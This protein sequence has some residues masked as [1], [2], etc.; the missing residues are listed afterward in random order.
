MADIDRLLQMLRSNNGTTR[1]D[2]CEELRMASS[3]PPEAIAALEATARDP[4]LIVADAAQRALAAHRPVAPQPKPAT[5]TDAATLPGAP[6]AVPPPPFVPQ[7]IQYVQMPSSAPNSPEY[8]F[9]LERRIMYLEG[10]LTSLS[11]GLSNASRPSQEASVRLPNTALLSGSFMSRA[12]A[13]WGH[14]FVA[15]LLIAIPLYII[16]F[17]I[18]STTY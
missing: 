5:S 13:V 8:V 10:Q 17:L 14:F 1:Y 3:I 18:G 7:A 16:F 15:Q 2:A 11:Q 4:G 12:F 6:S 9:A